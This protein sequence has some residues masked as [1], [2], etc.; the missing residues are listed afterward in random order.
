MREW[1]LIAVAAFSPV[2]VAPVSTVVVIA[3]ATAAEA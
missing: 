2:T 3:V 1:F